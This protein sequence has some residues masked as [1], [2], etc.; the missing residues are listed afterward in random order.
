MRSHASGG[1]S[2]IQGEV[3][4]DRPTFERL[5]VR[6]PVFTDYMR[7]VEEMQRAGRTA[8]TPIQTPADV[9]G[10]RAAIA[11]NVLTATDLD[12]QDTEALGI[13][14][15]D[16]ARGI[17]AAVP[18]LWKSAIYD[19]SMASPLPRHVVS[20]EVLPYPLMWWTFEDSIRLEGTEPGEH[21]DMDG[22]LIAH[23]GDHFYTATIGTK[24]DRAWMRLESIAYGRRYPD[25][26]PDPEHPR[27]ML[28]MLSFLNSP[29]IPKRSERLP[30][31]LR[32]TLERSGW[33][34]T[35][36]SQVQ[37]VD[38]RQAAANEEVEP[39]NGTA[40]WSHRWLVRGHHR[41]QWYPSS[42]SHKVIWIAPY[43][44]GPADLPFRGPVYRVVR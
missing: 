40:T 27:G 30:R 20:N 42:Q 25:D 9:L 32:R 22:F 24:G 26:W 33:A 21:A 5:L 29:Y 39:G 16:V 14:R 35:E 38:L 31:P 12:I 37:F 11:L 15:L 18:Y 10:E 2:V 34:E 43:V 13:S 6:D 23:A 1:K 7:R 41:A 4:A 28:A 36:T 44:K 8:R 17:Y 19:A 3:P